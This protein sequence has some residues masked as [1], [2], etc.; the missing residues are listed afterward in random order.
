VVGRRPA[1]DRGL[2]R[3][4]V[5][6]AC[7]DPHAHPYSQTDAQSETH[8]DTQQPHVR[9][10]LGADVGPDLS[11]SLSAHVG[12]HV[13]SHVDSHVGSHV[14]IVLNRDRA[15]PTAVVADVAVVVV[16]AA[17]G[18]ANHD[19]GLS[20]AGVWHTAWPFLVGTALALAWA[21]YAKDDPRTIKVG[22]RVWL[23]T[24]LVGMVLRRLTDAGTAP[25]FV[26]VAT[27]VLGALFLGWRLVARARRWTRP[28]T[29]H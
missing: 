11:P 23:L 4:D 29:R 21:A 28:F 27:L 26:V 1:P 2:D 18:R 17:I 10:D 12:A 9:A 7:P 20:L 19:D 22:I 6:A 24:L 14:G 16:F 25:S 15:W 13:G 8:S 5:G 3:R